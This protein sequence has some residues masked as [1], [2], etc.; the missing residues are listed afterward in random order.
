MYWYLNTNEDR[1]EIY[2][3]L[4]TL[5]KDEGIT[6]NSLYYNFSREKKTT[7]VTGPHRIEKVKVKK[8]TR[9]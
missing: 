9:K 1:A 8:A 2:S 3:S 6:E 7:F 4:S 5:A